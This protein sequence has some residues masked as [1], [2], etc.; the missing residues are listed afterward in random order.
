LTAFKRLFHEYIVDQYAKIEIGRIKYVKFHQ[1]EIRAELYSGLLDAINKNDK[2]DPKLI[3]KIIILPASFTGGPRQMMQLFQ[4]AMA[5]VRCFG[6]PDLFI[7]FTCN[8]N[9]IEI[10]N[11]LRP[12]EVPNDRPDLLVRVF[13]LKLKELIRDICKNQIFGR[14][15]GRV[16]VIEF[17]KRGLPHA[18]ILIILD[19]RDKPRTI[20]QIDQIVCAEIP[21]PQL[22]PQAYETVS[23]CMIHGPCGPSFPDSP[24]MVNGKCSK[25]FPKAYCE[26]TTQNSNGYS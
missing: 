19:E 11:E 22:Y 15:V 4:D 1:S 26:A 20:E 5:V 23:K 24:C 16:Y 6:K 14:V 18:H 9:W 17:Q 12:G 2:S 25:R 21:D 13:R 3:G 10:L 8:P 7:T